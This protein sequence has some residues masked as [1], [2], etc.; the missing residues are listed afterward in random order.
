MDSRTSLARTAG[1]ADVISRANS[2][3]EILRAASGCR[4]RSD[5][6]RSHAHRA[7]DALEKQYG[8]V[9]PG[10]PN[11]GLRMYDDF[12]ELLAQKAIDGV[13]KVA[14]DHWHVSMLLRSLQ[15]GKHV[16][17]EKPWASAS[18]RIWRR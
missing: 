15:A 6:V 14:P 11:R 18:S 13:Y 2:R 12:R 7:K 17:F 9:Q 3:T 10:R 1:I 4:P 16:H 5:A 8:L